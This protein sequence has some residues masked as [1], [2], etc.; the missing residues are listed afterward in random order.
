MSEVIERLYKI[1]PDLT[2]ICKDGKASAVR[3]ILAAS[4]PTFHAMLSGQFEEGNANVIK[5]PED[6]ANV[7]QAAIEY[8]QYGK[9]PIGDT[10]EVSLFL[11]KYDVNQSGLLAKLTDISYNSYNAMK[12][13]NKLPE[14]DMYTEIRQLS[15]MSIKRRLF[16]DYEKV[17]DKCGATEP[18]VCTR[19]GFGGTGLTGIPNTSFAP[20]QGPI[21]GASPAASTTACFGAPSMAR[22]DMPCNHGHIYTATKPALHNCKELGTFKVRKCTLNSDD[23]ETIGRAIIDYCVNL[24]PGAIQTKN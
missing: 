22:L 6:L 16:D 9:L 12:I 3:N 5:M 17:C 10:H 14:V 20:R 13:Y 1:V 7:V 23:Y 11:H 24:H 19:C 15:A 2:I 18:M 21:F 8:I 4:S